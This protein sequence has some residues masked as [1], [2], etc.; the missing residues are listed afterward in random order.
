MG[1]EGLDESYQSLEILIFLKGEFS[2]KLKG[3]SHK[4]G[5]FR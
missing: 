3:R 2:L 1:S 5:A 4:I